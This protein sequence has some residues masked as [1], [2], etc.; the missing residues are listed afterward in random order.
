MIWPFRR[1]PAPP[2]FVKPVDDW[3]PGDLAQCIARGGWSVDEPWMLEFTPKHGT[4]YIVTK[5]DVG[6]GAH[7]GAMQV[8]LCLKGN[9]LCWSATSFRRLRPCADELDRRAADKLPQVR[10][11]ETVD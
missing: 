3:K 1:K 7:N 2:P 6:I 11:P 9:P 10:Q 8:G 4:I 5:V